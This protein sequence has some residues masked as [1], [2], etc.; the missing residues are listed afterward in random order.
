MKPVQN[1][2]FT[3]IKQVAT[4]EDYDYVFDRSGQILMLFAKEKY[5]ITNLVLEKLK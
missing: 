2:L 1:R 3:A 5:D 4:D